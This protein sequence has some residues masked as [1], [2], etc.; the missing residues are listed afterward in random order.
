MINL[1]DTDL[2]WQIN[3]NGKEI[4]VTEY[5]YYEGY[6]LAGD[7]VRHLSLYFTL[8]NK[9]SEEIDEMEIILAKK[10]DNLTWE[11]FDDRFPIIDCEGNPVIVEKV[12]NSEVI[13]FKK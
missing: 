12:K 9:K 13:T 1:I 4:P 2:K 8:K 10:V 7:G 3:I 11:I 5:R 6:E